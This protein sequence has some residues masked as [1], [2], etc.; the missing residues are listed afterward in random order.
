MASQTT[1]VTDLALSIANT[2]NRFGFRAGPG[3]KVVEG[4]GGSKSVGIMKSNPPKLLGSQN[5]E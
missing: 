1:S 4:V 2:G 3:G 5:L